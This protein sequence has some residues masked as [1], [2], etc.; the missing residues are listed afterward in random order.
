LSAAS[1][2]PVSG[3]ISGPAGDCGAIAPA[4]ACDISTIPSLSGAASSPAAVAACRRFKVRS[5]QSFHISTSRRGATGGGNKK[6]ASL[7]AG[8]FVFGV[9]S[10][11]QLSGSTP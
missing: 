3:A 7:V 11:S 6:A 9:F 2:R 5:S 1:Q 10:R 8:G 4:R